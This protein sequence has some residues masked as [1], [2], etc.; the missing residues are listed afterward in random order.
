M[1]VAASIFS[2]L[3]LVCSRFWFHN[4]RG[5]NSWKAVIKDYVVCIKAV[6]IETMW[7][8]EL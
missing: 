6:L 7:T 3:G 5:V 4:K 8:E 2:Y 1:S